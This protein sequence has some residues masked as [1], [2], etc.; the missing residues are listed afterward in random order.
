MIEVKEYRGHI[1]NWEALCAELN[2]DKNLSKKEREDEILKKAYK[3]WGCDMAD[4]LYGMF[5]FALW[6]DENKQLVC[7][8]DQ[9]G[10]KPFYYYVTNNG[11]FLYGTMIRNI[12]EQDGFVKE[13]NKDALQLY[14]SL[15][16]VAGENT[17]FKGVKKLMPGYCLIWKDGKININRYWKPEFKPDNSKNLEEW[18]DEIHTTM[19]QMMKEIKTPDETAYSFLSGG[20][21]SS[22]V[23]AMSDAPSAGCCG[24]DDE[25]FDESGMAAE[26]AK[27]LNRKFS[28]CVISPE[29]YFDI[30]PY[31]MYNMEQPLG[32]ASAIAFTIGC[33]ETAKHT[34]L[35]YSGEGS[36]EFFGGYNMYRNAERYGDNLKNF[37]VGNTNIMKED[38]KQRILKYYNPDVQ[39]IDLVKSIYEETEGLDPLSKMSDVD[40]QIWLEGDIYLNVDKMSTA[41]GLEIRMPLTD[42]RVFDIASRMPSEYK[43]NSEQNKVAF[44][45][46]AARV[47]P[48]EIAFRKK[49]G[50][51]VPIRMWLADERYNK[52]VREKFK[53]EM[54][55]QF[56]NLDEIGA[57]FDD[58]INGNSDNWR[59]IWTIYTFLVWYEEY[60]VK[61]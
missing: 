6:D 55:A 28:R 35:C 14:M 1:R 38:E 29:Q 61:R 46:A 57:I 10:T 21:D 37:Y 47:L 7:I 11:D 36:D 58:Y 48:E 40:I 19:Q 9:F 45:T 31:V 24:Y 4:H 39:P 2:I 59:K 56:F 49:L 22:F 54:A 27:L 16:Y 13:I 3:K 20:V 44:R 30:V 25:R 34:K 18:A 15:T 42:R 26:T 52:D 17:F 12:M 43:V 50:F 32:D 5:A 60:F 51:I 33:M 23:L 41:A 8:R 53:S